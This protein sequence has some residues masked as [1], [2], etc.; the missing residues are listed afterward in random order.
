M[1]RGREGGGGS[2]G[3]RGD[4]R[5]RF[6]SHYPVTSVK[7]TP[8]PLLFIIIV[9]IFTIIIVI[10]IIVTIIIATIIVTFKFAKSGLVEGFCEVFVD[11]IGN[12]PAVV[13][14]QHHV[15]EDGDNDDD[16]G[17]DDGV[18]DDDGD[19]CDESHLARY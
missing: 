16:V 19:Q 3:I 2:W 10:I 11:D 15:P 4:K 14:V 1:G 5:L 8:A 17:N 9:T 13:G 7:A 18:G 6:L 12:L